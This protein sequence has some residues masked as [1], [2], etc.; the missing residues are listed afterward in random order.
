MCN[1]PRN[2]S[3]KTFIFM[4]FSNCLRRGCLNGL[5]LIHF[6][7]RLDLWSPVVACVNTKCG[8]FFN[9]VIF[10]VTALPRSLSLKNA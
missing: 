6:V 8:R 10:S 9:Y 5:S 1:F 3:Q 4:I 7:S 2:L